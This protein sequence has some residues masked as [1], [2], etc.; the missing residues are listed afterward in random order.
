MKTL[1]H[2]LLSVLLV[3]L[4]TG[5]FAQPKPASDRIDAIKVAFITRKLELTAAESEKFWPVYNDY[6]DKRDALRKPV[7]EAKRK[8]KNTD[9]SKLTDADYDAYVDA[10]LTYQEK[11][12]QLLKEYTA[13]LRKVLSRK[14]VA[15][16]FLAEEEFK[17]E[18]LKRVVDKPADK[19]GNN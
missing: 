8:I 19:K 9:P 6:Q 13:R 3:I 17:K 2:I 5:M 4:A 14:K 12:A 11:D 10:E 1:K 16:L 15:M 18:L 7:M